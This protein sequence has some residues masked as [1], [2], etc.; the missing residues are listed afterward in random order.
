MEQLILE[1]LV[2]DLLKLQQVLMLQTQ[3]V[4]EVPVMIYHYS[5]T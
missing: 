3:L 2:L 1:K 5:G 4:L